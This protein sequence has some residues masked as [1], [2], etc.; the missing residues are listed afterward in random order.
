MRRFVDRAQGKMAAGTC[1][2]MSSPSRF[3][4]ADSG[5]RIYG[6]TYKRIYRFFLSWKSDQIHRE[7]LRLASISFSAAS[8]GYLCM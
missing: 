1:R 3:V 5:E 4:L 7:W 6:Y 8:A 2:S